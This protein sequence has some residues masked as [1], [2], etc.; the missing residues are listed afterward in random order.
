MDDSLYQTTE[1]RR[2]WSRGRGRPARGWGRYVSGFDDPSRDRN[3]KE[4]LPRK[5]IATTRSVLY[6]IVLRAAFYIRS[7]DNPLFIR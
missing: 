1:E 5:D 3:R 7:V 6:F 2:F 4:G